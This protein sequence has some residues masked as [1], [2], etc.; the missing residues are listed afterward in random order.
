MPKS[1]FH[2]NSNDEN[3]FFGFGHAKK[4]M[5]NMENMMNQ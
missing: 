2:D 1:M 3:D 4:M 5:K